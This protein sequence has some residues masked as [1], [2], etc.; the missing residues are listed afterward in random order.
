MAKISNSPMEATVLELEA[1]KSFALSVAFTR[2]GGRPMPLDACVVTFTLASFE[3]PTAPPTVLVERTLVVD[4]P[5]TGVAALALQAADLDLDAGAYPFAI[6]LRQNGYSLVAVKGEVQVA[7]NVEA[8]ATG[9]TYSSVAAAGLVAVLAGQRVLY[10]STTAAV[11]PPSAGTGL[12][13]TGVASLR[14]P[15]AQGDGTWEWADQVQ[16]DWDAT[17]GPALILHKPTIPAAQVNADWDA[18]DGVAEILHKPDLDFVTDVTFT[19]SPT[20]DFTVTGD[21]ASGLH[22]TAATITPAGTELA[23]NVDLDTLTTP[24]RYWQSQSAEATTALH[25][26]V[27][28]AGSLEVLTNPSA[29]QTHQRYTEY[30]TG[31]S[32]GPTMWIRNRYLGVWSAWAP[33]SLDFIQRGDVV[34]PPVAAGGSSAAVPVTFPV[35]FSAV[36]TVLLQTQTSLPHGRG[37]TGTASLTATGFNAY[38][39]NTGTAATPNVT[40][41]WVA[42]G[43]R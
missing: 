19:D 5:S 25:Y 36:P 22:V 9:H 13:A 10:V 31:A 18:T 24:G 28:R 8:A 4:D 17:S 41:S 43:R 6:V 15:T 37:T 33:V 39:G 23:A 26:P 11:L 29:A 30:D 7:E 42:I 32:A 12:D 40:V 20:V 34:I 3:D 27:G 35:P 14:V 1:R 2:P 21:P 16:A 38:L